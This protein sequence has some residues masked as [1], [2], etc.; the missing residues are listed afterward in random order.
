[1]GTYP[2]PS[3]LQMTDISLSHQ[4]ITTCVYMRGPNNHI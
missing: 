2:F 4:L 3:H 1:M